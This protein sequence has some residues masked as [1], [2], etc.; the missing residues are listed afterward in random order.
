MKKICCWKGDD[1]SEIRWT[2]V[3]RTLS[4]WKESYRL[5]YID[6]CGIELTNPLQKRRYL[7]ILLNWRAKCSIW[8]NFRV[9]GKRRNVLLLD[10]W[11]YSSIFTLQTNVSG[12]GKTDVLCIGHSSILKHHINKLQTVKHRCKWLMKIPPIC[13]SSI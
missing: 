11:L 1:P 10:K 2:F 4:K 3:L 7:C 12:R 9:K 8:M 13:V 5:N 6:A